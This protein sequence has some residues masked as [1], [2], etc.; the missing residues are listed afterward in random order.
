MPFRLGIDLGTTYCA[1]TVIDKTTGNPVV[2]KNTEGT[3]IIPSAI[4]FKNGQYMAGLEAKEKMEDGDNNCA[5]FFKRSMG[6]KE[7]GTD[8]I[9]FTAE[10]GT[11]YE[12]GYTAVELSALL[13]MHLKKEAETVM[14]DTIKEAVITCPAYYYANERDCI[15]RAADIAGIKIQEIVEEPTAAA[16]P[17]GLR[18]WQAEAN[19]LVYDLGGGTF[20]VSVVE[21]D[22]RLRLKVKGTMGRKFLGGADFDDALSRVVLRKLANIA[23]IDPQYISDQEKNTIQVAMEALK[24]KMTTTESVNF[25]GVVGSQRVSADITRKDFESEC[26]YILDDTGILIDQ[27]LEKFNIE[28]KDISDILL[29]GGSTYMPCV[30]EYIQKLFNKPPLTSINPITAV[31]IGA[32]LRTLEASDSISEPTNKKPPSDIAEPLNGTVVARE[33]YGE[34]TTDIVATHTMGII[35]KNKE[36]TEYVN[37]HII[38]AGNHIPCKYARKFKYYTSKKANNELEIYVLQGESIIPSEC[39]PQF[40]YLVKGIRHVEEGETKGTLIRVQYSYDKNGLIHVQARQEN[41][42]KDLPIERTEIPAD[43]TKYYNPIGQNQTVKGFPFLKSSAGTDNVNQDVVSKYKTITFSNVEW[44]KYDNIRIHPAGLA[45]EPQKHLI[46]NEKAIE[47]HGYTVSE[48]NEGVYYT[49]GL[50]DSFEIECNI[51]TSE[52]KPHP[53]GKLSITL[54]IITANLDQYGGQMMLDRKNVA[55]VGSKFNLKMAV[56]NGEQYEIIIDGKT[57][58]SVDKKS[59]GNIEVRFGFTHGC[60]CCSLLSYAYV[61]NIEMKQSIGDAD[62]DAPTDTWKAVWET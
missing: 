40:R 5:L 6:E 60:H 58:G 38:P 51:N 39:N 45:N 18:N 37:Q 20:D 50:D 29:V 49:I 62:E 41:D 26:S 4:Y 54:G 22:N 28:R 19:I 24:Q 33:R 25:S 34:I 53:G 59:K 17:Y 36:G 15:K 8:S 55:S 30:R 3:Q 61:S 44:V 56:K 42:Q 52:I 11:S 47:F 46:A 32:A 1:L 9:C 14:N 13:L 31:A 21:M 2:L 16:L 27:L 48:M 12:R 23:G 43:M 10:K 57:V 7:N 35:A